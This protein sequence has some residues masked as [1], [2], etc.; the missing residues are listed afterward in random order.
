MMLGDHA[1]SPSVIEVLTGSPFGFQLLG[2]RLPLFD[3]YGWDPDQGLDAA[4]ELLGWTCRREGAEDEMQAFGKLRDAG[5]AIVGPVEMGLLLNHPGFTQPIGADHF[6]L[7]LEVGDD[8]VRYHDPHGFPYATLPVGAFL[9][10]WR[11][12]TIGYRATAYTIRSDFQRVGHVRDEEALRAC[13]LR[14]AAWLT[15]RE[16]V[17]VPPGTLGGRPA[18]DRLADMILAGLEPAIH[19][20]LVHFAIRLGA[21]RL[22]DAATALAGIGLDEAAYLADQQARLVGSLQYELVAGSAERAAETV[23]TLGPTYA[24]LA[25]RLR[26]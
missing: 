18:T 16:G 12:E 10:A 25:A 1:P 9:A 26:G 3:P 20:H 15:P 23:R 21:R 6:L 2:G 17:D 11:A 13:L 8:Q 7:V 24:D 5:P 19:G 22:T 14:A 4:T